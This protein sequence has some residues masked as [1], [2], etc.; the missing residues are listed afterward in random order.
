M[1]ELRINPA[2][3]AAGPVESV[4]VGGFGGA[5]VGAGQQQ[6]QQQQQGGGFEMGGYEGGGG[7]GGGGYYGSPDLGARR[8]EGRGRRM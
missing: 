4:G 6:Q 5:E 3:Q 2:M 7:G 8:G 1:E